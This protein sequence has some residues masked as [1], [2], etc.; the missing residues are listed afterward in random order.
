MSVSKEEFK[1]QRCSKC[2]KELHVVFLTEEEVKKWRRYRVKSNYGEF[3]AIYFAKVLDIGT[4][5]LFFH[6]ITGEELFRC[7]FLRKIHRKEKYKCLIHDIKPQVCK[8]FPFRENG[9]LKNNEAAKVC[10]EV[11]RLLLLKKKNR[12]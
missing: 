4:A 7:P 1:C 11:R 2:C 3:P 9:E 10:P 12:Q 5:D 6:P 8:D